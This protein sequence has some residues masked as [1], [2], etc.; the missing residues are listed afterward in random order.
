MI[1]DYEPKCYGHCPYDENHHPC[2]L[3]YED[4]EYCDLLLLYEHAFCCI[5]HK[6]ICL[7]YCESCHN[8]G[9]AEFEKALE[10]SEREAGP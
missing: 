9:V 7:D 6:E 3:N 10:E 1:D 5:K 4:D 2:I 8:E